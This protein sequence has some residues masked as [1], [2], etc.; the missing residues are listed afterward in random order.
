MVQSNKMYD[1]WGMNVG[2][3]EEIKE[4][5]METNLYLVAT[6]MIV[7]F[8]HSIFEFLAI[9]NGN[10][11]LN[12]PFIINSH[13][14]YLDIQFWRNVDSHKGLSLRTLYLNFFVEVKIK[15]FF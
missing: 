3:M 7:S 14:F 15:I 1:Q 12:T 9:K 8:L 13:H 5:I 10:T 4:M 2:D 11:S 6:T